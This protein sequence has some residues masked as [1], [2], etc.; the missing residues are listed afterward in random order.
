M[1]ND[2]AG[3]SRVKRTREETRATYDRIS[4]WYDPLEGYWEGKPKQVGLQKLAVKEGESV[5]EIGFGTG[6]GIVSLARAVGESGKVYGLELSPKMCAQT[7]RRVNQAGLGARVFLREGDA[8]A[9]PFDA[10]FFDAVFA[11]FVLEL[12]DSPEIP[13]V[14]SECH[15]V[16]KSRGHLGVVSLSKKGRSTFMRNLYEW[17][18]SKFP[19]ILDCRPIFVQQ[20]LEAAGFQMRDA[21]RMLLWGLSIEIV[22]AG[23]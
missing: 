3:I 6:H 8:V 10:N 1:L 2:K 23:K 12:F 4:R 22:I 5:L 14:L 21:T 17:G 11:S 15:R 18:H 19:S 13:D 16:L 7:Q 9:L 20:A